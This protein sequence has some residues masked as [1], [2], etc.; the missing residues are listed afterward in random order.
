[1][2]A[3]SIA[4]LRDAGPG[5]LPRVTGLR[6]PLSRCR[7]LA[8]MR[9]APPACSASARQPSDGLVAAGDDDLFAGFGLGERAPRA[10]P[11]L[12]RY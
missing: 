12:R 5:F 4:A 7:G 11:W 10:A 2:K 3:I 8:S 9:A 6:V 1:M